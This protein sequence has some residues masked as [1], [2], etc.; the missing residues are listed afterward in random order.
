[1]RRR[2]WVVGLVF[3]LVAGCSPSAAPRVDPIVAPVASAQ[4][5]ATAAARPPR[6]PPRRPRIAVTL[7]DASGSGAWANALRLEPDPASVVEECY[8]RALEDDPD[9]AGWLWVDARLDGS[10]GATT[11][12]LVESSPLPPALSACVVQR[13]RKVQP[14]Q[15]LELS[16]ARFYVSLSSVPLTP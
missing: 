1:M 12:K 15:G 14:P 16:P 10:G 11:T 6:P 13:L 5:S 7:F 8:E 4:P 2:P 9:V 3:A